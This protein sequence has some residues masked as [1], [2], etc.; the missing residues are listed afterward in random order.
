MDTPS[1]VKFRNLSEMNL[2]GD[3]LEGLIK[4]EKEKQIID[5]RI[6]YD[7]YCKFNYIKSPGGEGLELIDKESIEKANKVINFIISSLGKN[8]MSGRDIT[9]I[10]LPIFIND[11]RSMLEL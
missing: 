2:F 6:N 7:E 1:M 10:A 5:Y 9:N 4:E 8:F 3:M 11:D